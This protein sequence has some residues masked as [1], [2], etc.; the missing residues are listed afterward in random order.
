MRDSRRKRMEELKEVAAY[1]TASVDED[2]VA[3]HCVIL[4]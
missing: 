1:V 3:R 2:G 4:A